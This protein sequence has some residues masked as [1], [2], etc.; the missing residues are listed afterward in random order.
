MSDAE[1]MDQA[2]HLKSKGTEYFKMGL[3]AEAAERYREGCQLLEHPKRLGDRLVDLR[4][5]VLEEERSSNADAKR[6]RLVE[7]GGTVVRNRHRPAADSG[8]TVPGDGL[9]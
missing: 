6:R 4:I 9:E 5:E 7:K 1:V 3:W 2:Y 8:R